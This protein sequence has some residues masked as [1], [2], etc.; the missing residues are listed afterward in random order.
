MGSWYFDGIFMVFGWGKVGVKG[1]C[2]MAFGSKNGGDLG[3]PG[4]AHFWLK[5]HY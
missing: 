2:F 4:Y 1:Q 3:I 5:S